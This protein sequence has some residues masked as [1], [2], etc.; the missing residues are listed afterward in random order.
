M[1]K[2]GDMVLYESHSVIHGRP[3]PLQGNYY[4]NVFVHYEVIGSKSETGEYYLDEGGRESR[5]AG[6][7][8]YI[9]PGSQWADEWRQKNPN[10]WELF[11]SI[12]VKRAVEEGNIDK[13][14]IQAVMNKTKL[15]EGDQNDWQPIHLAARAGQIDVVDFLLR[16]GADVDAITNHGRG[17]TPLKIAEDSLG[18]EHDLCSLLRNAGGHSVNVAG[19]EL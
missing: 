1:S 17:W 9:I 3:F 13:L 2:L 7:P 6:L 16:N 18:E 12:N 15:Y 14:K 5:E 19:D 10:G 11:A 4:A 8:P